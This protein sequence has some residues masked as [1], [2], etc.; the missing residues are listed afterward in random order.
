MDHP[1]SQRFACDNHATCERGIRHF[2]ASQPGHAPG[3]MHV[4]SCSITIG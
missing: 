1:V 4:A 3:V 2:S